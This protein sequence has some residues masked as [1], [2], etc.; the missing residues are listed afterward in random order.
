MAIISTL[1]YT[2]ANG[3]AVDATPVMADLNQIV[4][5]VNANAVASASLAASGGAG[6]VGYS[7][8]ASGSV[9]RTVAAKLAESVSVL[10]FGAD[11]TGVADST[12]AIQAAID[13]LGTAGGII[14]FPQHGTFQIASNLTI[15]QNNIVLDVGYAVLNLNDAT[16]T[17][18]HITLGNG[19]TQVQNCYVIGGIYTRTQAATSGA[20]VNFNYAAI[21]GLISNFYIYGASKIYNG[22][23]ISQ[24]TE[25]KVLDGHIQGTVSDGVYA[26]GTSTSLTID[27][28]VDR[29]RIDSVGGNG[30]NFADYVQGV[31]VRSNVIY[32]CGLAGVTFSGGTAGASQQ[33]SF[34]V[35]NNDIDS[36]T[37]NGVFAQ[38][39][40][41]LKITGN[42]ISAGSGNQ[43]NI[44]IGAG[45]SAVLVE[46]NDLYSAS[47]TNDSVDVQ[48]TGEGISILGNY[49]GGGRYGINAAASA[50]IDVKNNTIAY[51]AQWGLY[52]ANNPA[53]AHVIGNT[54]IGNTSG[55][56]T[57]SA[58]TGVCYIANNPGYNP[59]GTAYG[60]VWGASPWTY[61]AGSSPETIY[62][63]GGTVT[64]VQ[65]NGVT[66][67][68]QTNSSFYLAPQQSAVITYTSAG[69][70]SKSVH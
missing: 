34:M 49:I 9:S 51:C 13:S 64:N 42:W 35:Q 56:I 29:T 25:I 32:A 60:G 41:K 26:I 39:C 31:Y 63:M 50:N 69:T 18:D 67:T 40:S 54:F 11:P 2:I 1:P 53:S 55:A 20:V 45:M 15:T 23:K 38:N 8:G 3:Q 7:Q 22:V 46:G 47:T 62:L 24:G 19:T 5:N 68:N 14:T 17:K 27:I 70:L 37:S 66:V 48:T 12:A 43:T 59:V 16:G 57:G 6:L 61:T 4:S 28:T 44:Q 65:V 10:D 58:S 52:L 36:C 33:Y 21:C 30:V